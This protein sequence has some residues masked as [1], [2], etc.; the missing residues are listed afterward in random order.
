MQVGFVIEEGGIILFTHNDEFC[1]FTVLAQGITLDIVILFNNLKLT[2]TS[3]D[4]TIKI[5]TFRHETSDKP[6]N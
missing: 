1:E 3:G 4:Q 2:A 6:L 5:A